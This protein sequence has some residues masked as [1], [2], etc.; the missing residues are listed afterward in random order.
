MYGNCI[1]YAVRQWWQRG[2]YVIVRRSQWYPGPHMMWSPDLVTFEA[3]VPVY[4]RHWAK[5]RIIPPLWFK[6]Q[7]KRW[8]GAEP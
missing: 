1:S 2:G 4:M 6:G 7:I 3:F 8:T 5:K